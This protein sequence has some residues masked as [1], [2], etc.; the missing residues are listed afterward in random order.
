MHHVAIEENGLKSVSVGWNIAGEDLHAWD[1]E[2]IVYTGWMTAAMPS[3]AAVLHGH[4]R[5]M[6]ETSDF[7]RIRRVGK[8]RPAYRKCGPPQPGKRTWG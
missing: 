5:V 1:P 3:S 8:G 2:A 4:R 7:A 6:T